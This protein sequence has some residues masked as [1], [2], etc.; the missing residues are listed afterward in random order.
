MRGRHRCV[1]QKIVGTAA[2]LQEVEGMRGHLM[3]TSEDRR[4]E[5]IRGREGRGCESKTERQLL[6]E[7]HRVITG[8]CQCLIR[9][10][11]KWCLNVID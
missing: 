2:M 1:L 4:G 5:S 3:R 9:S 11:V 10:I 8:M 7:G 6:S